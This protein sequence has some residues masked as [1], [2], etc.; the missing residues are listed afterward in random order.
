MKAVG[1]TRYLPITDPESLRDVDLPSPEPHGKDLLV[2]IEAISVNTVDTK[3]RRSNGLDHHEA[4]P[5][6]LHWDAAGVVEAT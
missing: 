5:Q 1:L 6:V 3:I 2:R 4:L